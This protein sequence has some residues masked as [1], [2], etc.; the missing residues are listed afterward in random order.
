VL[1]SGELDEEFM[2][3]LLRSMESDWIDRSTR[4]TLT[5]LK[6]CNSKPSNNFIAIVD[7]G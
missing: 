4:A 7:L 5:L 6:L 3:Q 2:R 1:G